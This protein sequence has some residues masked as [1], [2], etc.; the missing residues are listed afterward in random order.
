MN[1]K[2]TIYSLVA[3]LTSSTI[4]ILSI[5]NSVKAHEQIQAQIPNPSPM[6]YGREIRVEVDKPFIEMMIPHHQSAIEMAEITLSRSQNPEVRKLAESIIEEQTREIEQMRTWYKQWYGTEVP[7]TDMNMDMRNEMGEA[8][9]IAMQQQEMMDREMI[10]ALKN[11]SDVDQEFLR[12]MIRH[13]QMATMMAGLVVNSG[14]HREIRDLAEAIIKS[15]SAEIAQMQ[16]LLQSMN[17]S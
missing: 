12:Q 6:H 10:E 13:H 2:F 17:N 14:R 1:T 11:A 3:L 4:T 7:M 15:Q 9:M 16:Q 5:T 8:M